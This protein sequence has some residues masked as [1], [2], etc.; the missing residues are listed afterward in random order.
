MKEEALIKDATQ[1][2]TSTWRKHIEDIS[3]EL[4]IYEQ[5][6][7]LSKEALKPQIKKEIES[8]IQVEIENEAEQKTKVSH[9][10]Q[11]KKEIKIGV[12]PKYMDKLSRKQCN[13]IIR[14]RASVLMVP[15]CDIFL[16]WHLYT[17]N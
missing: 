13:A 5:M 1:S 17:C 9:W 8:K 11:W 14:T 15:G 2:E 7:I 10:R 12:R 6:T 16:M 3:K 4:N